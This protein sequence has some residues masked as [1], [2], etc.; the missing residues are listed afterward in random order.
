[1]KRVQDF[2]VARDVF[3]TLMESLVLFE[4]SEMAS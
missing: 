1:M 3:H 4:D 2:A